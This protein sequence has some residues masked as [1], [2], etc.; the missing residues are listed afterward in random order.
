VKR[1]ASACA[2]ALALALGCGGDSLTTGLREPLRVED[3]Q[4]RDG[5]LPGLPPLTAADLN[6]G[7]QPVAPF[8]TPPEVSG[9]IVSPSDV[10]FGVSGRASTDAYA[11]GFALAGLGSGYWT[12]PVSAP[13]PSNNDELTWRVSVDFGP[14]VPPGLQRLLV[15]AFDGARHAGTQREIE[16]CVRAPTADNLNVC[17]ATLEPPGLVVSLSW[18]NAADLDIELVAPDGSVVDRSN[19]RGNGPGTQG[20]QLERDANANCQPS[21]VPRENV[22]WQTRPPAGSYLVYVNLQDNCGAASAAFS[23]S[24]HESAPGDVDGEFRQVETFRAASSL[25]GLTANG[26]AARGLFVTEL[27]ID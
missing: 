21:G 7:A 27:V 5:P 25:A 6:A 11:V 10:A 9:R 2:L 3:A 8:S 4:F 18:D 20:A 13:D 15:A 14:S 1:R 16:L 26:G 23:V 24:A 22:I 17:D 12:V 19:T